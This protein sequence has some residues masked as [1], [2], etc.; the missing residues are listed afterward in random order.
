MLSAMA[1][2]DAPGVRV[3]KKV[4]LDYKERPCVTLAEAA[5]RLGLT[6]EAVRQAIARGS[7][8][9]T[10]VGPHLHLVT[11]QS[12]VAYK[13]TRAE[14]RQAQARARRQKARAAAKRQPKVAAEAPVEAAVEPADTATPA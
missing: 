13:A 9:C 14:V 4:V 5:K 10:V 8:A 12:L 7:L 6:K 3:D 2:Q 11:V 1:K